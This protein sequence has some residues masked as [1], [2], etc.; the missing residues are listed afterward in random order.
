MP[1][2]R[3]KLW[4]FVLEGLGSFAAVYYLNYLFFL[5]RDAYGF[6]N[7][8]NLAVC[9][10]HGLCYTLASWQAGRFAQRFGYFTALKT[11]FG[12]IIASLCLGAL[13][14]PVLAK[15]L[16]LLV[17]TVGICWMWPAL[18]ALVT[19]GESDRGVARM[20]GIYSLTWAA[21]AAAA[22]FT[23]GALFDHL[24]PRSIYWVPIGI[25]VLQW[26]ILRWIE[27]RPGADHLAQAHAP[28]TPSTPSAHAP[29]PVAR[30]QPVPPQ[31][32]LWM[33]WFCNPFAYVAVSTLSAVIPQLAGRFGLS[34]TQSGL[35]FS[36]WMFVRIGAFA[37]FWH[38]TRWHYR[39]RWLLAAFVALIVGFMGLV[40]APA[41]WMAMVAQ[42]FLGI[43]LGLIYYSSLFY[44][45]DVGDTRGEHGGLHEA[46][47]GVGVC[48]GPAIGALALQVAPGVPNAGM[49]TISGLLCLGLAGL[50]LLRW[51]GRRGVA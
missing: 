1:A 20:V 19:D 51:H 13:L 37:V 32:F 14:E 49:W 10:A 24:G 25:H 2:R 46:A 36:V 16:L 34:A 40:L 18:E 42:V 30:T 31:V 33:G 50:G 43:A 39:F 21:T 26:L 28:S 44:S 15:V 3:L 29:E 17:W 6:G 47:L 41:F 5:L 8:E 7:R 23:G 48:V 38:W 4:F 45:M 35:L 11:G 22:N 12:L 27:T 9:A